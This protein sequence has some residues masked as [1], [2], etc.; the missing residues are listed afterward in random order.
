MVWEY[1]TGGSVKS[2]PELSKDGAV[3]FIG[4]NDH[5]VYALNAAD[6]LVLWKY[7]TGYQVE[8]S[9][10]L[11]Q[12]D[13][14]LFIGS[15]DSNV[16]ALNLPY[17]CSNNQCTLAAGGGPL[18]ECRKECGTTTYK[19]LD[20]KCQPAAGGASYDACNAICGKDA[21]ATKAAWPS[22]I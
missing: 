3:L 2:S 1:A 8:S 16:Y 9:P 19:C 13:A 20:N 5:N 18:G 22:K 7:A 12:D 21:A 6:G 4:S 14:T 15:E 17:R 11:S 10:R